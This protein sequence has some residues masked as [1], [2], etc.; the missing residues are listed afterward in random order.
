MNTVFINSLNIISPLGNTAAE[1]YVSVVNGI[2]GVQQHLRSDISDQSFWASLINDKIIDAVISGNDTDNF[3]RYEKLIIASVSDALEKSDINSGDED[4]I[5]IFSTTKGNITL[6][7]KELDQHGVADKVNLMQSAEKISKYF[8]N[9]NTP[10]VISNACISGVV[11][12]LYAQRLLDEGRYKNAVVTG[13]D[14]INRFIYSGFNSFQALSSGNCRPFSDS[15]DGIN[16]GEAAATVVLSVEKKSDNKYALCVL[17]GAIT[18]DSNHI[19]GPS[20]TGEE[21]A[22]AIEK[23]IRLSGADKNDIGFISAHGTATSFNDEME[24]KAINLAGL[25]KVPVN[26]LKGFFGHTLGAAG[27]VESVIGI[28]ALEAGEI[29]PTS[30]YTY[31]CVKPEINVSDSVIKNP[32]M[33]YFLKTASGFGG[34][35]A[36]LI[37]SKS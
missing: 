19:S 7:E 20:R 33:K 13:A 16:L 10:F 26:S 27:L 5:F 37:F 3:S 36:A 21:L 1:N 6:L 28:L 30:G 11:A 22:V 25:E 34:C 31:P 15:R 12:L 23:A 2:S 8:N 4:T 18:N 29:I 35:N 24:A 9:N 14:C 17:N 32:G